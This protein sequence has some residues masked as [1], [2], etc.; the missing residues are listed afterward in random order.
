MKLCDFGSL[1]P[2]EPLQII[3]GIMLNNRVISPNGWMEVFLV[4]SRLKLHL[5]A[6]F[7]PSGQLM[8]LRTRTSAPETFTISA[9][10]TR[11]LFIKKLIV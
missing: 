11:V 8:R 6:A 7:G 4:D 10:L 1:Y 3:R 9:G 2:K 5:L